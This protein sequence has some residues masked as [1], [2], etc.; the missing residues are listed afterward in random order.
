MVH[1]VRD[2]LANQHLMNLVSWVIILIFAIVGSIKGLYAKVMPVAVLI[3]SP[4]IGIMVMNRMDPIA[5]SRFLTFAVATAAAWVILTL[6][7]KLG[8][9]IANWFIIGWLNHIAGFI[10]GG[11]EGYIIVSIIRAILS[12]ASV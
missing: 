11:L 3:F 7:R 12:I 5:G 6:L 2:I 8:G 4:I 10:I 9:L 1:T